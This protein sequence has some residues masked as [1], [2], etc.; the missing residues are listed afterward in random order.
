M[1]VYEIG[2]KQYL[3][4]N[5]SP[6]IEN[7]GCILSSIEDEEIKKELKN[8]LKGLVDISDLD[9][10]EGPLVEDDE[11][12]RIIGLELNKFVRHLNK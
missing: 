12:L 9:G 5:V 3:S 7:M 2:L 10:S 8:G 6:F 1:N 11:Q 4:V